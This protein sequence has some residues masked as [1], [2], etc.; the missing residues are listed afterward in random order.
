MVQTHSLTEP[1]DCVIIVGPTACGKT[2][3]AIELAKQINGEIINADSQQIY[4]Q[5]S[6]GTAKP[7]T[8]E[9]EG[10][11]HHLLDIVDPTDT[12]SVAEYKKLATETIANIQHRNK[13]PII[14][15][16]TGYYIDS[17]LYDQSYGLVEGNAS[18]RD[19]YN[20]LATEKGNE[21]VHSI[22]KA[23]DSVSASKI[24]PN[25]IKRVIRALEIYEITGKPMSSTMTKTRTALN[26]LI[27][28]MNID[29]NKLYKRIEQRVDIMINSGLEQEVQQLLNNGVSFDNQCMQAIGY[30]EWQKYF[31]GEQN[32]PDTIELI[33]KNTRHYAKR[34]ITWF[35]N[36]LPYS[37]KF[38]IGSNSLTEIINTIIKELNKKHD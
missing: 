1:Y 30:K 20:K 5:L 35:N 8:Q 10:I 7:T 28:Y 31:T 15:G 19:K 11:K 4:K 21:Y 12:F 29:R 18:I 36:S 37:Y 16:G 9:Q 17:L 23:V 25:D 14:V 6:I 33:K 26:P 13:L 3:L 2:K 22:L 38:D 32:L 34:Q 24:H 27:I